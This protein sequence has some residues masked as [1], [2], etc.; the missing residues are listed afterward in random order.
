LHGEESFYIDQ[1]S[2][3]I[4]KNILTDDE[5][6]FNQTVLYGLD[7]DANTLIST[8]K[9]CP[10]MGNY[11][12]VILKEAQMMKQ[13]DAIASYVANPVKST[14]FVI[15]HKN[16]PLDGRK[17]LLKNA[18]KSAVVLESK[19]IKEDKVPA[20]IKEYVQ[21][22]AY[23]INDRNAQMLSDYLGNDLSK[24]TNEIS[25][26]FLNVTKGSEIT[27]ELIEQYIGISKDFNMFELV[28]A[29]AYKDTI[30]ATR[31]VNYFMQ[32]PK[33]GPLPVILTNI[34]RYFQKILIIY[35]LKDTSPNNIAAE[36]KVPVFFLKDYQIG[37]KNYSLKKIRKVFQQLR[38]YDL[39]SK[40]ID[41]ANIQ[42]G[43]L[44]RELVFKIMH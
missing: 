20:W 21:G 28:N 41:S 2:D 30:R 1:I 33:E 26:L 3:Y 32:N 22:E 5:K 44:L 4:E 36:L 24:I 7:T 25:K 27:P 39:M 40:G 8:V 11:H 14:I 38:K 10:M 13:I 43:Q 17:L 19:K 6:E 23:R 16:K 29:I 9:R 31:I 15:C 18:K 37:V 12:V 34:F 42:E 35:G